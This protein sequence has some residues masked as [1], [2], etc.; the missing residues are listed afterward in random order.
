MKK[1]IQFLFYGCS[2]LLVAAQMAAPDSA[3]YLSLPGPKNQDTTKFATFYIIRSDGEIAKNYWLGIFFNNVSMVRADNDMSYG[4]K[5]AGTG[6]VEIWT[7]NEQKSSVNIHVD[8]GKTY[9]LQ[10]TMIAGGKIG[11]PKLE[12]LDEN[13]GK[14]ALAKIRTPPLYVYDPDPFTDSKYIWPSSPKSGFAHMQFSLPLSTR[15]F[16]IRPLIGFMFSYYNKMVSPT[17][18]EADGAYG[19]KMNLSGKEDFVKYAAK[20]T[21]NLKKSSNKYATIQSIEEDSLLSRADYTYGLYFTEEDSK[22]NVEVN[23]KRPVLELRQYNVLLYKKDQ[24]TDKGNLY[25][26]YFSERG[27]PQELHTK[28]EIRSKIQ[29]L[30]NSCEFGDF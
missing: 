27:L 22:P 15:H 19:S 28:E 3:R 23:G 18:T 30:L 17:F 21:N 24:Q 7:E 12:Q 10:L 8:E 11:F 4:I 6:D 26:I 13:A 9:Y 29:H 1:I 25:S 20:Q 5:Y 14:N 16:F 2:P